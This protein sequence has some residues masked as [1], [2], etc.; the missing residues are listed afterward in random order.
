ML[1]S[2]TISL[3]VFT[4]FVAVATAF[5]TG[6]QPR[7]HDKSV[8]KGQQLMEGAALGGFALSMAAAGLGGASSSST[9][10][11]GSS[12]GLSAKGQEILDY[13]NDGGSVGLVW[14]T[15]LETTWK[16]NVAFNSEA[17]VV[18]EWNSTSVADLLSQDFWDRYTSFSIS[19]FKMD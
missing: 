13:I 4:V 16:T 11:D 18:K 3:V 10:K 6:S 8:T 9:K 17:P 19:Q 1:V 2:R 14:I 15:A 12:L 5:Y 7:H